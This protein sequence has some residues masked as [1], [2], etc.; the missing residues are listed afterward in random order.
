L[1]RDESHA[2]KKPTA[3]NSPIVIGEA[4]LQPLVFTESA[5]AVATTWLIFTSRMSGKSA[6]P[7]RASAFCVLCTDN[8]MFDCPDTSQTSLL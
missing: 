3:E 5:G 8:F 4:A 2:Q 1:R 7:I 6:L